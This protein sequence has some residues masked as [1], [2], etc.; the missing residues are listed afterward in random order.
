MIIKDATIH[1]RVKQ[2]LKEKAK[3]HFEEKGI[4]LSA[5]ISMYLTKIT[6]KKS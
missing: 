5:A 6:S 4:T 1:I 2:L 3:K